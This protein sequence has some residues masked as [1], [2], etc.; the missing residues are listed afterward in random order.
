ME[1]TKSVLTPHPATGIGAVARRLY[2]EVWNGRR[3]DVAQEL[4]HPEFSTA[5]A[6]GL[7]G[8]AAKVA[9]IRGYHAT[10]PDLRVE[11]AHLVEGADQVAAHLVISGTDTGGFKGRP[12]TGRPVRT[13]VA[14]FLTFADQRIVGDWVGSD[15]LGTLVQLGVLPDPWGSDPT[16]R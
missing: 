7:R 8:G 2:D 4:F 16:P 13:W 1:T 3:Y 5:A 10:L 14:E 6:P 9:A 12:A 11:I 15:W